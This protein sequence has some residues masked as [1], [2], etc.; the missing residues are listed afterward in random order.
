MGSFLEQIK[1]G[2]ELSYNSATGT[3]SFIAFASALAHIPRAIIF[4]NQSNTVV[5]ISD[6]GTNTFK[7]FAAGQQ[8]V[9]D[10]QTNNSQPAGVYGWKTGTQFYASSAAGV[11]LFYISYVY[12]I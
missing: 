6:D 7:T 3:G 1:A 9:L 4:D 11:G 10:C 5:K 12:A 8:M 2:T